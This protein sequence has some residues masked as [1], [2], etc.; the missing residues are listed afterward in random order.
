MNVTKKSYPPITSISAG[1]FIIVSIFY[2]NVHK[3][4]M[5][6]SILGITIPSIVIIIDLTT[7]LK[8]KKREI[9]KQNNN[10]AESSDNL[11]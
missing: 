1:T 9:K 8:K 10:L 3:E 7:W 5:L 2:L 6:S 4:T 11:K